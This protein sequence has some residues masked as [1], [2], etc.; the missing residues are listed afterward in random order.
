MT[1]IRSHTEFARFTNFESLVKKL[2]NTVPECFLSDSEDLNQR[3]P[4]NRLGK[5]DPSRGPNTSDPSYASLH[6]NSSD[7]TSHG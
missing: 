4:P 2:R 1:I 6:R 3:S 5:E 7:K